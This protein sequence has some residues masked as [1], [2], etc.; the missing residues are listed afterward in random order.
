M[1][2]IAMAVCMFGYEFI[3]V[4]GC[5]WH[6]H[7]EKHASGG[8]GLLVKKNICSKLLLKTE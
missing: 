3:D 8:V 1:P 2:Q 4:P 6:R 7:D 5:V